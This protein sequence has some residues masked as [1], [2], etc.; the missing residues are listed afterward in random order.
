MQT[1]N[2]IEN[3]GTSAGLVGY[4]AV[5]VLDEIAGFCSWVETCGMKVVIDKSVGGHPAGSRCT[6]RAEEVLKVLVVGGRFGLDFTSTQMLV[7]D[8]NKPGN[9]VKMKAVA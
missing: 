3:A 7:W 9:Y 6:F 2:K 8:L 5:Q 1:V 4:T